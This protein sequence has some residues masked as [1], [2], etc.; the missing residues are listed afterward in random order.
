MKIHDK[1]YLQLW[2]D[3]G[4]PSDNPTWCE[5]RINATDIAYAI[6]P[7][8]CMCGGGIRVRWVP[9]SEVISEDEQKRIKE[10]KER[11]EKEGI[12]TAKD[13]ING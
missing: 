8:Q 3:C 13:S 4:E 10:E 5:D 6:D 7:G 2:D 9:N 11:L 12:G 1:I